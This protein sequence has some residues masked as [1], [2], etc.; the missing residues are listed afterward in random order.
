MHHSKIINYCEQILGTI[1]NCNDLM[2]SNYYDYRLGAS[3]CREQKLVHSWNRSACGC[4]ACQSTEMRK[5]VLPELGAGQDLL[6][7]AAWIAQTSWEGTV[8]LLQHY[9]VFSRRTP[10]SNLILR[11]STYSREFNLA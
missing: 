4:T 2:L 5:A 8:V 7:F 3:V 1:P 10:D 6:D 9:H 11:E